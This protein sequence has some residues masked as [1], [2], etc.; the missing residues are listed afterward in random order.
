[1][2]KRYGDYTISILIGFI[3]AL[4]IIFGIYI[5][6]NKI[7][8]PTKTE[9]T[10]D[11][12]KILSADWNIYQTKFDTGLSAYAPDETKSKVDWDYYCSNY[13]SNWEWNKLANWHWT[14]QQK[15]DLTCKS[16]YDGI[17]GNGLEN[18]NG[19]ILY[20]GTRY[21]GLGASLDYSE[22]HEVKICCTSNF[23]SGE[24]CDSITLPAKC[25]VQD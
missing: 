5:S 17:L 13:N 2:A 7:N 12:F 23:K 11:D 9:L 20:N 19:F 3:V 18:T 15:L 16:Y 25:S 14:T 10:E 22:N 6:I 8:T 21:S 4:I 1:M 24:I